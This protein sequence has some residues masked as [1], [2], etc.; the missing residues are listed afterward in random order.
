MLDTG[1]VVIR[2][3]SVEVRSLESQDALDRMLMPLGHM[4]LVACPRC[5]GVAHA[6][7]VSERQERQYLS[8][9][10]CCH[11]HGER[12]Q[13]YFGIPG[14]KL[15]QLSYDIVDELREQIK[16]NPPSAMP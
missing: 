6:A 13:Q 15:P 12:F 3:G 10:W 14:L 16:S 8:S 11:T 9:L 5:D 4:G 2:R 7:L 1:V